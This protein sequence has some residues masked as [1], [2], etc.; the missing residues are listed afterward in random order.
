VISNKLGWLSE[1]W[2]LDGDYP[3]LYAFL[4]AG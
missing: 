3:I 1:D 4:S 2:Q